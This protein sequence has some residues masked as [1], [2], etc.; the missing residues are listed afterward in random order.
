MMDV[1]CSSCGRP[2]E[3]L[4]KLIK[5]PEAK[6][7]SG[8]CRREQLEKKDQKLESYILSRLLELKGTN[9]CPSLISKEY[10]K[11]DWKPFHQRVVKAM[12]RLKIKSKIEILQKNTKVKD[13]NFKGPI[14][15]KLTHN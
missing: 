8:L 13:L 10:F 5:N 7:C 12:R 15:V 4:K 6:Y 2:M 3:N 14:R 1:F 9:I 11:D